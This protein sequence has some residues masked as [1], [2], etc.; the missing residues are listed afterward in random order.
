VRKREDGDE[1]MDRDVARGRDGMYERR[2]QERADGRGDRKRQ[3]QISGNAR[4][5]DIR[6]TGRGRGG[7]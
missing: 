4:I 2:S 6:R 5:R 3:L 1:G 7:R